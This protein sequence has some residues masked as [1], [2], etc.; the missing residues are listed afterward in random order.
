MLH[1]KEASELN[2]VIK[3]GDEIISNHDGILNNHEILTKDFELY[4]LN[5]IKMYPVNRKI[6][7]VIEV[8][9]HNSYSNIN[10]LQQI[11]KRHFSYKYKEAK[12]FSKVQF[13]E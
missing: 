8:K 4:I 11:I 12:F 10:K 9:E 2:I 1:H 3:N 6:E 5:L 7:L 13:K